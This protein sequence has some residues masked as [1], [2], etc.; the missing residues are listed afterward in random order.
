MDSTS[1]LYLFIPLGKIKLKRKKKEEKNEKGRKF[2][3]S[4]L[5]QMGFNLFPQSHN[6]TKIY[7]SFVVQ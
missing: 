5:K 4:R 2:V 7:K 3:S 6:F 1:T